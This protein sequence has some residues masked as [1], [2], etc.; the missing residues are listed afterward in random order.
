MRFFAQILCLAVLL[1]AFT[2]DPAPVETASSPTSAVRYATRTPSPSL[3]PVPPPTRRVSLATD[4]PSAETPVPSVTPLPR[5]SKY[6]FPLQPPEAATYG[7][8][9]KGHGYPATD[10]FAKVGTQFVAVT[11]GV[12]E[13]VSGTDRWNPA[14]PDPAKRSGLAVAIIGDDGWRYY[15]S[16][17]SGIAPGIYPGARVKLGTL[18]GF[19]GASGDAVGKLPHLHFGI[20][21]PTTPGDWKTRRGEIDPFPYLNWWKR[22]K[23]VSP[24]FP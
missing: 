9:V 20:S 21:R 5:P 16:H 12:V 23:N 6:T 7:E 19:V 11:D 10:L 24:Q 15:G 2:G 13:F 4:F 3:T 17:L 1:T 14:Y 22:G 18:L 8:G